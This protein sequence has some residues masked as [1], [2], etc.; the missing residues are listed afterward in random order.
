MK[1]KQMRHRIQNQNSV[2]ERHPR[3]I[4]AATATAAPSAMLAAVSGAITAS[5][6]ASVAAPAAAT[7]ITVV[8]ALPGGVPLPVTPISTVLGVEAAAIAHP[9]PLVE[10][11]LVAAAAGASTAPRTAVSSFPP[12]LAPLGREAASAAVS[13]S[14]IAS[15]VAASSS[16]ALRAAGGS[17]IA[18]VAVTPGALPSWRMRSRSRGEKTTMCA[19]DDISVQGINL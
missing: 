6:S 5:I 1:K 4:P 12:G 3:S 7:T 19:Q 8:A 15:T 16:L 10:T 11:P 13:A 2:G 17:S 9:C 14:T 18:P